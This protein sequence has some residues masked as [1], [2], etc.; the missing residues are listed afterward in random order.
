[1]TIV[2]FLFTKM[3]AEKKEG[4]KGKINISNNISIKDVAQAKVSFGA[5]DQQGI[6]FHFHFKSKYEPKAGEISFDGNVLYLIDKKDAKKILDNWKKDKK[7]EKTVMRN[8]L[9][10]VLTRCN[11]QALI[12]SKEIGLP[13]PIPLPKVG[14]K[15]A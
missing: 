9:N 10:T 7:I 1:M 11:I 13:P 3:N 4:V 2:G 12:L 6:G 14:S 8:I 5:K 15:K